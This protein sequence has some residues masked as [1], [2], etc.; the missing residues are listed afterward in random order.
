M[1]FSHCIIRRALME[2]ENLILKCVKLGCM[3]FLVSSQQAHSTDSAESILFSNYFDEDYDYL[4]PE[5]Y[6]YLSRKSQSEIENA[7]KLVINKYP[8]CKSSVVMDVS[9][10]AVLFIDQ[11]SDEDIIPI[12]SEYKDE[13]GNKLSDIDQEKALDIYRDVIHPSLIRI[14]IAEM[15]GETDIYD[16]Y[17]KEIDK[18]GN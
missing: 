3:M 10:S 11:I 4:S 7:V 14:Y 9:I 5:L 1:I 12:L 2:S 13:D 16:A 15:L 6:K 8:Q 17:N 18:D